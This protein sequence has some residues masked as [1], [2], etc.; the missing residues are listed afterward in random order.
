VALPSAEKQRSHGPRPS[1]VE[2][3]RALLLISGNV[4]EDRFWSESWT[5][6]D[7]VLAQLTD[8]LRRSRAV[9]TIAIDEGWADDRDVSVF[10]GR[11][12][13]LDVRSLVEEHAAGRSLVR[14]ST[15]LRPTGFGVLAAF[16]LGAALLVGAVYGIAVRWPLAGSIVGAL[17]VL[18]ILIVIWRTAQ[19]TAIVRRAIDKVTVGS[20]MVVMRSGAT[21]LPIVAPS[22]LRMYGLRTAMIFVLMIVSLGASTFMLREAATGPVIGG[23]KGYAGDYS[24]PMEAWLDTPGGIAVA[25]NGD[26]YIADSNND[27]IRRVDARNTIIEPVAGNHDLG[28]GFSGDNG[29]AIVAQLDTPDGV[30]IAPDG[31]LI[32]ADSHNDRIRRVDRPTGII[33]TIAGSGE[34]GYDGD[35]KP[36]TEAALNTPS[37]VAAA[38]NGDIYIADTLNYRIRMIDAKTGLI[39]TVAGDGTPGD[40]QKVG[41]GGR[42]TEAH[43]NMPADV[44][45]DA[46]NGDIYIAD[47]HHNR[48]RRV[49]AKTHIITTV[50]G[51]GKWGYGGDDGPATQALLSG[52][53]G[54]A[55]VPEPQG[56]V[57][58][59]VADYYNEHV[60]AVGPDGIIR[61]L[62]DEGREAFGT[63]TRV[64][65]AASGPRRGWL[66][67][68]DSSEDKVV[69]LI[70]PRIA[71]SLLPRPVAPARKVG[72]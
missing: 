71:P 19:A 24:S 22:L 66:Y 56:K 49:D 69:P 62:S 45:I 20:G 72:G 31:D 1:L 29:P 60:R 50:A 68:T 43:L 55:I 26:V 61:D 67:V 2:M 53:A 41:D 23:R 35:E 13:W 65:F 47:M 8:W 15:H 3:W 42:A 40:G 4:M 33:T 51:S 17:A 6:A 54:I 30:A 7:R 52:P 57:T 39:H 28:A 27:V 38:P 25:A 64:A 37:A 63:P 14:I 46:R 11:W 48:V 34:N 59:F 18:L 9:R 12:A 10:A 44:A 5:S 32:V 36:A 21:R 58:I 70:I 16:V